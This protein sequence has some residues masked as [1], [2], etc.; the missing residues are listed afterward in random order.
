[1]TLEYGAKLNDVG[2]KVQEETKRAIETMTDLKVKE[3]NVHIEGI[4]RT[5]NEETDSRL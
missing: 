2:L 4:N 3:V 5:K 1:L